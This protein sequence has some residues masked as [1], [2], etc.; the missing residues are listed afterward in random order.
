[1]RRLRTQYSAVELFVI[2]P[3]VGLVTALIVYV[4]KRAV[5]FCTSLMQYLFGFV[6]SPFS[7]PREIYAVAEPGDLRI[8]AML[9]LGAL[10]SA[11]ATAL[12][13]ESREFGVNVSVKAFHESRAISFKVPIARLV[14]AVF[15]IASGGSAGRLGPA[16]ET[17]A[18]LAGNLAKALSANKEVSRRCVIA[19][20][21][22]AVSATLKAP[23]GAVVYAIEIPYVKGIEL[24]A[25]ATAAIASATA[26]ATTIAIDQPPKP[27][28][29][30][31][32]PITQALTPEAIATYILLALYITPFTYIHAKA[33]RTLEEKLTKL[34]IPQPLKPILGA[35]ALATIAL[36][37]TPA[38][39]G[40][41]TEILNALTTTA[42][43]PTIPNNWLHTATLAI[44]KTTAT[45]L[46]TATGL[47]GGLYAPTITT[48]A[49]AGASYTQLLQQ[50]TQQPPP[51]PPQTYITAAAAALYA[52]TTKTPIATTIIATETTQNPT[53]L[54]PTLTTTLITNTILN[55]TTIYKQ[56]RRKDF[57][58]DN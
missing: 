48:G 10:A 51:L 32:P 46:T 24:S 38:V 58:Y 3:V 45:A 26:Y 13:S 49:I 54:I 31:T 19:G 57:P 40:P 33:I 5:D 28:P 34:N 50:I 2:A 55:K 8:A 43:H 47:A 41:G 7:P 56:Q 6:D 1:M 35:T 25:I 52:T 27:P 4:F 16:V 12:V 15:T 18:S 11:A 30:P 36:A 42:T 37:T 17:G 29:Q 53:N 9:V 39:L 14:A 44:L 20:I 22:A 23:I 21:A